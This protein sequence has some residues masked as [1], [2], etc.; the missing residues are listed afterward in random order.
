MRTPTGSR[1]E[2]PTS[3]SNTL[4]PGVTQAGAA[5]RSTGGGTLKLWRDFGAGANDNGPRFP[6]GL[7][8][9]LQPARR[10][11]P[12]PLQAVKPATCRARIV[13]PYGQ[14]RPASIA[15][16]WRRSGAWPR[17]RSGRRTLHH[18]PAR[19][20]AHPAAPKT[21]AGMIHQEVTT[22]RRL[23]HVPAT[24]SSRMPSYCIAI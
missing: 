9:R 2:R 3:W 16:A 1:K 15:R 23:P 14:H 5:L 13:H 24:W 7:T 11:G 19:I 6:E 8:R 4:G 12:L 21:T 22:A 20:N 18:H 10:I 17:P